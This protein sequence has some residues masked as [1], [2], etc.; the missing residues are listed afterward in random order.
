ML[1]RLEVAQ[2]CSGH[3]QD[4]KINSITIKVYMQWGGG[5]RAS[6]GQEEK[7]KWGEERTQWEWSGFGEDFGIK[8]VPIFYNRSMKYHQ[9]QVCQLNFKRNCVSGVKLW[10]LNKL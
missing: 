9:L 7:D 10:L 5:G 3:N 4:K 8:T 6:S 1:I 2:I